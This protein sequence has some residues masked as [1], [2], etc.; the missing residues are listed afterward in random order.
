[1]K[2]LW[3]GLI[4]E[5]TIKKPQICSKCEGNLKYS[6]VGEYVCVTCGNVEFD[7]YGKVRNFIEKNPKATV[8]ETC[9]ATGVSKNIIYR[10]VND[11][12]L[13][14]KP[15]QDN[16]EVWKNERKQTV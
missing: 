1:M 15:N 8:K 5:E 12:K 4:H 3:E 10:L 14:I 9:E 6:G 11:G 7:D 2:D 16:Q 13:E